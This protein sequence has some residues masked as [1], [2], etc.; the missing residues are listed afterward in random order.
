MSLKVGDKAPEFS[1]FNQNGEK[2][3]LKDFSG[4]NIILYFY[5]RD[6]TPGCTTQACNLRD[7]YKQIQ[8]SGYIILGVSSDSVKSHDKFIKKHDLPF[9]LIADEDKSIH[10]L[11]GTWIEKKMYGK[12][13]MGTARWTF[14]IDENGVIKEII[15]KVKTKEHTQ[16]I[17][18]E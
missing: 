8:D 3:S 14:I 13:Y 15:E 10:K 7:N 9:D 1:S 16:Q 11:Y 12:V 5:P 2:I 6:N 4:K 17:I 18:G